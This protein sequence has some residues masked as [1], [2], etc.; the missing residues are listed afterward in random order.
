MNN[1]SDKQKESFIDHGYLVLENVIDGKY[2]SP[3][4]DELMSYGKK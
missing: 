1:L 3:V 2:L 4:I